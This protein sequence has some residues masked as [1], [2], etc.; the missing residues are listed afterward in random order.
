[1]FLQVHRWLEVCLWW[2]WSGIQTQVCTVW[3]PAPCSLG[4]GITQSIW[5]TQLTYSSSLWLLLSQERKIPDSGQGN[6]SQLYD[7]L[8]SLT[9]PG[10]PG[11]IMWATISHCAEEFCP[12]IHSSHRCSVGCGQLGD[13]FLWGKWMA[14][15]RWVLINVRSVPSETGSCSF[16]NQPSIFG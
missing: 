15:T 9:N 5:S 1:M 16:I 13:I 11:V 7:L 14:Q 3:K 4:L 10:P 2:W 8:K 6:G 12:F